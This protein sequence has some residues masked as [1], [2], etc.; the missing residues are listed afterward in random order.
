M[1]RE[2][3][4]PLICL[5]IAWL[6]LS[7]TLPQPASSQG[8]T[9]R[10][11]YLPLIKTFS[12]PDDRAPLQ[13][14][15]S[16][17]ATGQIQG[18]QG[19]IGVPADG[20]RDDGDLRRGRLQSY[21]FSSVITPTTQAENIVLDNNTGLMW[22]RDMQRL[23][24]D[25]PSGV[26]G[27][28]QLNKSYRWSEALEKS[29]ELVYG[30]HDDWRLPT[31]KEMQTLVHYGRSVPSINTAVFPTAF[32]DYPNGYFWSTT[33]YST[34][35]HRA[36]YVNFLNGH[37]WPFAKETRLGLRPVR[38][39]GTT[40]PI[41]LLRTGQTTVYQGDTGETGT[42]T[43][44]DGDL[45]LGLQQSYDYADD[46]QINTEAENIVT[47]RNTELMWVRDPLLITGD[48]G[49]STP[50]DWQTSID[51]VNQLTYG[52]Y[53]DW[54]MPNLIELESISQAG[55]A[56][57]TVD[58]AVFPN[59]P[60]DPN[61]AE[62]AFFWS[63]TTSAYD[64]DEA[65]PGSNGAWYVTTVLGSTNFG[66]P[67]TTPYDP[68]KS[69]PGYVR[70]VRDLSE[71]A[72]DPLYLAQVQ[73][74]A[75]FQSITQAS[76]LAD[77][78]R[79]GKFMLA[80]E[81]NAP[82]S[83]AYQDA[84]QYPLHHEFLVQ[85]FPE[86]FA[87]LTVQEYI[88]LVSQRAT[89]GYYAGNLRSF[90]N[91]QGERVYGFDI[92]TDPTDESELL[93]E[94][95]IEALY[96]QLATSMQLRPL[97]Y[98]PTQPAALALANSWTGPTFPIDYP[99]Q[100]ASPDYEAYIIGQTYGVVRLFT[101]EDLIKAAEDGELSRQEIVVIDSAPTDLESIVAG[102]VTGAR[103]GDL[104]HLNI[105]AARRGTPNAYVNESH[106]AFAEYEN[107][108]ARLSL[109][110]QG[111][112]VETDVDL[113]AAEQWWAT[114][115]PLTVTLRALQTWPG[116]INSYPP[117]IRCQGWLSLSISTQSSWKTTPIHQAAPMPN[118]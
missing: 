44:D 10:D 117:N 17:L 103:Q 76:T 110:R 19:N 85:A 84:N 98:S 89:R 23:A 86:Q 29:Q 113:A 62:A 80:L 92:F 118:I 18:Y 83:A 94:Q 73:T 97:V 26:A 75:E 12:S 51:R 5:L 6:T 116:S 70:P 69:R 78:Q 21:E 54:R 68:A 34:E 114:S 52:G 38:T 112:Y 20:N 31:L 36:Y 81:A 63:S 42:G 82:F 64:K 33:T 79:A 14:S 13:Q 9:P 60:T 53:S 88:A 46:G 77:V 105:R 72:P 95:E 4:I 28:I 87:G 30:G 22:I 66:T 109:A 106:A 27:N 15:D 57:S 43:G 96:S 8:T 7:I 32:N 11:L 111:Y 58:P 71:P 1:K 61:D 74:A 91:E 3:R 90:D 115:R 100:A 107:Q 93:T 65:T 59:L 35:P 39:A 49:I 16:L 56:N 2:I 102:I 55:R 108:L 48:T 45:R 40:D 50:L 99:A 104:S 47:D 25:D 67:P 37:T 24:G 41:A 101:L